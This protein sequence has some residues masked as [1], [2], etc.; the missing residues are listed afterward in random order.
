MTI[1]EAPFTLIDCETAG[2]EKT[3]DLLEIAAH[4]IPGE[5][6]FATLVRPT[7][8]IPPEASAIHHLVEADFVD[9]PDRETALHA[10]QTWLDPEAVLI[11]HN[12]PFDRGF[13][14]E[15]NERVWVDTLRL[16]RHLLPDL[17]SYKNAA[18]WYH[19]GGH[20]ITDRLHGAVA[21]ITVTRFIFERLIERYRAW[22]QEKCNAE[23][24][25]RSEEIDSLLAF[26]ARPIM[27]KRWMIGPTD[28]K[29]RLLSEVD[30]GLIKWALRQT[31][32]DADFRWNVE[33][34]AQRRAAAA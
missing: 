22:A 12:A 11:A 16:A 4:R 10:L 32:L 33:R 17:P 15:L 5:A 1:D 3:D 18:L 27:M 24:L 20:K 14:P 19:L 29:G 6:S 23:Q 21:D 13:L 2:L 7:R 9:A 8:P 31:G 34:E 28:A 26:I 30:H 25:A